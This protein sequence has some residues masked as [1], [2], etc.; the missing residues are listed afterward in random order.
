[1]ISGLSNRN[2]D[3]LGDDDVVIV[4]VFR[5]GRDGGVAFHQTGD[6]SNGWFPHVNDRRRV[7]YQLGNFL[8]LLSVNALSH[9][10]VPCLHFR[11]NG[12]WRR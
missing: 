2:I 6:C 10:V 8:R 12:E 9:R 11:R 3:G 5:R 4:H 7:F 1:M